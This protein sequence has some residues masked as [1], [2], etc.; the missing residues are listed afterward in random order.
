[1]SSQ[2]TTGVTAATPTIDEINEILGRKL[3]LSE[4]TAHQAGQPLKIALEQLQRL[5]RVLGW[6][7]TPT[8]A[9]CLNADGT[10]CC[11]RCGQT[12]IEHVGE[13]PCDLRDVNG[14]NEG[15]ELVITDTFRACGSEGDW[16]LQCR[17]CVFEFN[18]PV[19]IEVEWN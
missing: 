16:W 2:T 13:G 15:G 5:V 19:G 7:P 17:H 1:M 11:P 6:H 3:G 12:R 14:F 4:M 8:K 10:L 9:E 18:L